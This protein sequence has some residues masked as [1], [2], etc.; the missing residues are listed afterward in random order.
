MPGNTQ[1]YENMQPV[2]SNA[3]YQQEEH[4]RS[5]EVQKYL[6]GVRFPANKFDLFEHAVERQAPSRIIDILNQLP[7]SEFGSPNANKQSIYNSFDDLMR[8]IDSPR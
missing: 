4:N 7:T 5:V 1:A 8:A 2:D 6:Q 3:A